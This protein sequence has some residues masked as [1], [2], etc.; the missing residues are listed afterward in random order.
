MAYVS[1]E[2]ITLSYEGLDVVSNLSFD[3][4]SGDYLCIVGENGS[5]KSTLL[6]GIL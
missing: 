4:Q 2:N 5:G 6:K 1:C 3:V